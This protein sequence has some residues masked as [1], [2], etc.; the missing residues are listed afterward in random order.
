MKRESPTYELFS[1]TF[2][3]SKRLC[4]S[5]PLPSA[6]VTETQR[7]S[8]LSYK[9]TLDGL[10]H[11]LTLIA[12]KHGKDEYGRPESAA[13]APG[14]HAGSENAALRKSLCGNAPIN[15]RGTV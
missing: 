10:T 7:D 12:L 11:F 5:T 4:N 14:G 9:Y 8:C 2:A 6:M 3:F 1:D 15:N 13:D